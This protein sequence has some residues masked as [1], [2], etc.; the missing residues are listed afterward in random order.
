MTD[1]FPTDD[2]AKTHRTTALSLEANR[3]GMKLRRK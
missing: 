3:Q 2:A 1:T